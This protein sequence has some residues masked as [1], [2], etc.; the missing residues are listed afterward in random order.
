MALPKRSEQQYIEIEK[1]KDYEVTQCI[2]YEMAIRNPEVKT[3][4][5][6]RNAIDVFGDFTQ[7]E[8]NALLKVQSYKQADKFMRAYFR[9]KPERKKWLDN[10]TRLDAEIKKVSYF[11][12][13]TISDGMLSQLLE[14]PS[15][16]KYLEKGSQR[17]QALKSSIIKKEGLGI[18]K[19]FEDDGTALTN[20]GATINYEALYPKFSR[21]LPEIPT[22]TSKEIDLLLNL[23]L[24]TKDMTALIEAIKNVYDK[25]QG[26]AYKVHTPLHVAS[27]IDQEI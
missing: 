26:E 2:A 6:K 3:L 16:K 8:I 23:A 19:M 22:E 21:P 10:E 9:S 1:F 4:V 11:N 27:D 24:P 18:K 7:S 20:T 25:Y 12:I 15:F 5:A 14:N 17:N 13:P